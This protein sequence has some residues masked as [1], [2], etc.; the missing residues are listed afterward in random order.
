[1]VLL[2][3]FGPG[4]LETPS[5]GADEVFVRMR[6]SAVNPFDVKIVTRTVPYSPATQA[7]LLRYLPAARLPGTTPWDEMFARWLAYDPCER[8]ASGRDTLARLRLRYLDCGR[9]EYGLDIGARVFAQR[10]RDLGL[11]VRHEE[12]DDDHRYVGYRYEISLPV[13]AEVLDRA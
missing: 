1:M 4:E 11:E 13:L 7:L 12:F 10:V 6:A 3:A 2:L 5:V 9:R 8:V